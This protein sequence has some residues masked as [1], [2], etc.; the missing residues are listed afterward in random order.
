V[1]IARPMLPRPGETIGPI[2]DLFELGTYQ[3][4]RPR[5]WRILL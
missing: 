2:F 4:N 3:P 1:A 5:G